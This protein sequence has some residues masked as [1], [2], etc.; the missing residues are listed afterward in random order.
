MKDRMEKVTFVHNQPFCEIE[1]KN[2]D[3]K[4]MNTQY[5]EKKVK[6]LGREREEPTIKPLTARRSHFD[7]TLISVPT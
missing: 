2:K 6:F 1:K 7:S 5:E 4:S 3:E